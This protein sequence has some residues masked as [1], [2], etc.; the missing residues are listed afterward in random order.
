MIYGV[1][2]KI[3]LLPDEVSFS[4]EHGKKVF[5]RVKEFARPKSG[6]YFLSGSLH[7][8]YLAKDNIDQEYLIV[9]EKK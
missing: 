4:G 3:W 8:A 1:G 5:Y 7:E 2:D 9:E 6:E